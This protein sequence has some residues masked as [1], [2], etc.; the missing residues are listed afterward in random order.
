MVLTYNGILF[1]NLKTLLK[2]FSWSHFCEF[3]F[4]L[5]QALKVDVG[6]SRNNFFRSLEM[7]EMLEN[8]QNLKNMPFLVFLGGGEGGKIFWGLPNRFSTNPERIV[9]VRE[10]APSK[11]G[12][13]CIALF[14][15]PRADD[16]VVVDD[17]LM[18][19]CNIY[20]FQFFSKKLF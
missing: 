16:D 7:L 4:V 13:L 9:K 20:I 11:I 19:A 8:V 10:S 15:V 1:Q 2:Y 12:L 17:R 3:F 18:M 5:F 6:V 14:T